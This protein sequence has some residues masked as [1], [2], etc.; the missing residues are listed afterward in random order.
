MACPGRTIPGAAI[1]CWRRGAGD[2]G[3]MGRR[4]GAGGLGFRGAGAAPRCE[5]VPP[6][7]SLSSTFRRGGLDLEA[8][9]ERLRWF[10]LFAPPLLLA[11]FSACASDFSFR[12]QRTL[13]GGGT[14]LA[15]NA[16]KRSLQVQA[17]TA[18]CQN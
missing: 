11:A 2:T 7:F 10:S 8:R 5:F 16:V 12:W 15:V 17:L 3:P 14:R 1:Y 9:A 13:E 4:R 6:L 18:R